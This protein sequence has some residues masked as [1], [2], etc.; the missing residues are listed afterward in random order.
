MY[1]PN[2]RT[3][4]FL[5]LLLSTSIVFPSSPLHYIQH[6][7]QPTFLGAP[8]AYYRRSQHGAHTCASSRCMHAHIESARGACRRGHSSSLF[9]IRVSVVG[10][11]FPRS[12]HPTTSTT[13]VAG[14]YRPTRKR[15]TE[16][17][18]ECG[19]KRM[20]AAFLFTT[21]ALYALSRSFFL[22]CNFCPT[23]TIIRRK[24]QPGTR[25]F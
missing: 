22:Q 8:V 21:Y 17:H 10:S 2:L 14:N 7:A 15:G 1:H 6:T 18:K 5:L 3:L 12:I 24:S 4:R 13:A 9:I 25:V 16:T 23:A 20:A 11:L 19:E